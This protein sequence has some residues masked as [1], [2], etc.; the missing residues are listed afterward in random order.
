MQ[1][2]EFILED[3]Q[4]PCTVFWE[5][6]RVILAAQPKGMESCIF[7]PNEDIVM[8]T[9]WPRYANGVS[10][11]VRGRG[12]DFSASGAVGTYYARIADWAQRHPS[13]KMLMINMHPFIR[14]PIM[15]RGMQNVYIADGCLSELDRSVNP[16]CISMPALPIQVSG[17][18]YHTEGRRKYLA[19]FQGVLSHPVRAALGQFHDGDKFIIKIVEK[20]RHNTLKLDATAGR[21]D[22]DYRDIMENADFAF[23]PRGDALFSYRLLEAMSFGCI[24]IILSDNWVLP[25]HRLIDWSSCSL[26]PREDEI[27][28]CV[29]LLKGLSDAEVLHRK[30]KVLEIYQ[31][32]FASLETILTQGVLVE[33]EQCLAQK[34]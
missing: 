1:S 18:D 29:A 26:R 3:A 21:A 32:Y 9:N 22:D 24:P 15:L 31:R 28:G 6:A 25:F 5:K 2:I 12:H 13:E 19:S 16:R 33:L 8:E 14:V 27:G 30:R 7:V 11:Y 23:I 4:M 17:Q 20:N 10:S 34:P